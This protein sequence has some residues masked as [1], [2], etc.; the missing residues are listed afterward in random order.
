MTGDE[1]FRACDRHSDE[2]ATLRKTGAEYE[3]MWKRMVE[4]LKK[5]ESRGTKI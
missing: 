2:T 4:Y 1:I 5:S 3:H